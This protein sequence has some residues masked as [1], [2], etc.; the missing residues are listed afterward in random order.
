MMQFV[1]DNVTADVL[2]VLYLGCECDKC[3]LT[4]YI[5]FYIANI[6]NDTICKYYAEDNADRVLRLNYLY[7][8]S[9][10]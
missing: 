4:Q 3:S 6:A 9:I 2:S 8:F 10:N 7:T 1:K 5:V